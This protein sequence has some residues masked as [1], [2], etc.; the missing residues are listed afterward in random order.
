MRNIDKKFI[1]DNL[2]ILDVASRY[3]EIVKIGNRY[4]AKENP[5][6]E[7]KKS[8]LF[9]YPESNLFYD[10]GTRIS[11]DVIQF[12][13]YMEN[14]SF[15]EAINIAASMLN[16][17]TETDYNTYKVTYSHSVI[18]KVNT[19][20]NSYPSKEE[21]IS[22]VH[23][24]HNFLLNSHKLQK[25]LFDIRGINIHTIREKQIGYNFIF[26]KI[27]SKYFPKG[28]VIPTFNSNLLVENIFIRRTSKKECDKYGKYHFIGKTKN[29]V[30]FSNTGTHYPTII[31]EGDF[32]AILISQE[33]KNVNV[34]S[35]RGVAINNN[36]IEI[37]KNYSNIYLLLDNDDAGVA[38]SK[39]ILSKVPYSKY[40]AL[41]EG[42]KDICELH[43]NGTVISKF[44]YD[45]LEMNTLA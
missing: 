11:G 13:Q 23:E 40:I 21:L 44:I 33:V 28:W 42:I 12:I 34:L 36:V 3:C 22:F 4:K 6:R 27:G 20:Q 2:S 14:V 31:V 25:E 41:P 1:K 29:P 45:I 35:L 8:S 24:S 32:D 7:E 16:N 15:L 38:A 9:F 43:Q 37:I 19:T 5:L 26:K 10:F 18:N 17:I 39:H 30:F